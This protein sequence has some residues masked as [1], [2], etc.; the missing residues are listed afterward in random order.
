MNISVPQNATPW[1]LVE[2]YGRF[3]I[4][5]DPIFRIFCSTVFEDGS[6]RLLLNISTHVLD[7]M[8]ARVTRKR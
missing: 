7:S 2:N 3:V 6:S 5:A 1:I 4:R 8:A